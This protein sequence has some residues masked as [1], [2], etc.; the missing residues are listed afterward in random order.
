M[1]QQDKGT[2]KNSLSM[3][4]QRDFVDSEEVK[5]RHNLLYGKALLTKLF[6]NKIAIQREIG[7]FRVPHK[8]RLLEDPSLLLQYTE[9]CSPGE[10]LAFWHQL[11]ETASD[12]IEPQQRLLRLLSP[13]RCGAL[14]LELSEDEQ[15]EV[16]ARSLHPGRSTYRSAL[17]AALVAIEP[18]ERVDILQHA[19]PDVRRDFLQYLPAEE[20]AETEFL[21]SFHEEQAAGIM[22]TRYSV[23]YPDMT[24]SEALSLIRSSEELADLEIFYYHYIVDTDG[25]LLGVLTL[26]KLLLAA[27]QEYIREIM[28]SKVY[29][30][31]SNTEQEQVME[32]LEE[33][34]L[35]AVPVVDD[36]QRMLGIVTFDDVMDL[37][38]QE[39][40][41][42]I[43][44]LGGVTSQRADLMDNFLQA[45]IR[46]LLTRRLPWLVLLL[47]T[48]TLTSSLLKHF[49]TLL[50]TLP[51][52]T[53]FIPLITQT[54]G[55]VGSQSSVLM[56]RSISAHNIRFRNLPA[57]LAKELLVALALAL[58]MG[59]LVFLRNQWFLPEL[60]WQHNLA[61]SLGLGAVVLFAA[62]IGIFVPLLLSF[63]KMD[64]TVASGPLMATL[65]DVIG[66]GLYFLVIQIFAEHFHI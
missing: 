31:K 15:G 35:L 44:N 34:N 53:M 6:G 62:L 43:S 60:A 10:L 37:I 2:S 42:N 61:V 1:Q 8:I 49:Q 56:I 23:L 28:N 32:L 12:V 45:P 5:P 14:L 64:P 13:E 25:V 24:V 63:M 52:L 18:D 46:Y 30:V 54:G 48:G 29:Y 59:L 40:A 21:L 19:R 58:I 11:S 51:M 55:N 7:I 20:Q 38:R 17:V 26:Q 39:Q 3:L 65:I 33:Q 47:L 4:N 16:L 50:L 27:D 22:T 66:L 57:A 36:R 41:Q 9:E